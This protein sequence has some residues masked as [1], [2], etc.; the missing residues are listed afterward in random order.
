MRLWLL[1]ATT[2]V[3]H[4]LLPRV[5]RAQVNIERL[6]SD[7]K[8][9]PATATIEGSFTGRTGNVES[10]VF[11]GAATGAAKYKRHRFFGSTSADYARFAHKTTVSKS[12]VHFRYN[13]ELLTWLFAEAFVQ[14]Q[15][16]K[17]QRLLLRELAGVGPRVRVFDEPNLALAIG[18]AAMLEFERI[19]VAPGALD[20]ATTLTSRSSSYA[21]ATWK[22]DSRV[23]ALGTVYVQPRFADFADVR[24]LFEASLVTDI[25]QRLGVR[26][27][28]T[29]RHDSRPPTEV[30]TTDLEI[31][32]ALVLKF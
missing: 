26:V 25:T 16:D 27:I 8:I 9:A 2:L 20:S 6:R 14:Q 10:V 22:A 29:V 15:Q 5:A 18:T 12:F 24:I 19:A 31:K 7:L 4:V 23:R 30:K 1:F 3:L 17:F 21:S 13:L 11:G 28:A 32:N